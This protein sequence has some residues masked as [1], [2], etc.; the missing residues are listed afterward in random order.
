MSPEILDVTLENLLDAPSELLD[1]VYWELADDAP[2][3]PRFLKEEWFSSTLLE[4]GSCGKL[5]REGRKVV[6]F[7]QYA[8]PSLF[9]RLS[10]FRCGR[11][12]AD[13]LYLAYCYLVRGRRGRGIGTDLVRAVARDLVDRGFR[14]IEAV[15]DR[16]AASDW[17]L[18]ADFLSANRFAVLR[19]DPRFPLM[20]L[21]L[22]AVPRP[23]M[24]EAAS[25]AIPAPGGDA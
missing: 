1:A 2:V 10:A 6:G 18:P 12:S 17:V 24:A 21:D 25:A 22:T 19:E 13:A 7:A 23:V 16:E 5:A 11:V 20:R 3:D 9:P 14:A 15:G 8:P 4:W